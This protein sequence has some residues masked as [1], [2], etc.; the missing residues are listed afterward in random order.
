MID[1]VIV[2]KQF[3]A[4]GVVIGS[5]NSNCEVDQ[6]FVHTVMKEAGNMSVTFHK[7]SD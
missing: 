6:E 4:N 2:C 7:A 1:D 5:L 3:K